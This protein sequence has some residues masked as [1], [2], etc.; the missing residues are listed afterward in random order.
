M[1]A[2]QAGAAAEPRPLGAGAPVELSLSGMLAEYTRLVAPKKGAGRLVFINLQ[3]RLLS[4]VEAFARTLAKHAARFEADAAAVVA[5]D[6]S[7]ADD[8][9]IGLDAESAEDAEDDRAAAAAQRLAAPTGRARDLLTE[10]RALAE[11]HRHAADAKVRALVDW[12]R[13]HQCPAVALGGATARGAWSDR[14][15]IIFT[16]YGHTKTYLK[17][18]L[19]TACEGTLRGPERIGVFDGGMAEDRREKLQEAWNGPPDKH[20]VR[21]L[22]ATDAAREGVNL[23]GH[24]QDLFHFDLPWNPARIEQRNG[25]IDRTLQPEPEVR[26]MYFVYPQRAED[27]VLAAVV[28]KIETIK[29]ELGSL[30]SVVLDRVE[31]ALAQGIDAGT[32]AELRRAEEVGQ[33]KRDAAKREGE[34]TRGDGER[35]KKEIDE[36]AAILNRSRKLLELDPVLLREAIDVGLGWAGAG[37]LAGPVPVV[38]EERTRENEPKKSKLLSFTLPAMDDSWQATLDSVR[39]S[40]DRDESLGEWR[41]RPLLPVVFEPPRKLATPVAHLHLAHPFVQRILARFLAQGT[42]A[43][44]LARV[45]ALL[46]PQDS[47]SHVIAFGRLSVFGRGAAR[48]H[49]QLVSVA[50]TWRAQT[51]ELIPFASEDDR[52]AIKKIERL[53]ALAPELGDV[54]DKARQDVLASAPAHFAALWP[55]VEAEADAEATSAERLLKLRGRAEGDALRDL[56]GGQITA[57][58]AA[59]GMKQMSFGDTLTDRAQQQQWDE[60]RKFLRG[61]LQELRRERDSEPRE[62]EQSYEI[63]RRRVE[64]VGMVY[65]V[66]GTR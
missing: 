36:A 62:I 55:H 63:V 6:A 11:Q 21:I 3:K 46:D 12:I 1:R 29:S 16:E 42:A 13:A 14:R 7:E 19:G 53:F 52:E 34:A 48:L 38:E 4:S 35:L 15:V 27:D 40:R 41:R 18:L 50:A 51:R 10:M 65:L 54:D 33:D 39:P 58:E 2:V 25:R 20:P 56:I 30:G 17:N 37:S 60:D 5:G 23:Q 22:I 47:E 28:K 9:E 8:Y 49:E 44:D 57:G 31:A 32:A 24:C 66:A 64:P 45:T 61:R 26:C 59:V 43:H